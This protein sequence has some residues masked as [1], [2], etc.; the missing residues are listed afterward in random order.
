MATGKQRVWVIVA[1][2]KKFDMLAKTIQLLQKQYE[3]GALNQ[4]A[5]RRAV[6]PEQVEI[7]RM[8]AENLRL[9]TEVSILKK[10]RR[11]SLARGCDTRSSKAT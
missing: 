1:T 4:Q 9:K 7:G 5:G 10:Q 3:A 11:I 6:S 8:K 2:G